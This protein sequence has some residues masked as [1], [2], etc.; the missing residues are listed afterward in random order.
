MFNYYGDTD[1]FREILTKSMEKTSFEWSTI[2]HRD[3]A[4]RLISAVP[5][6]CCN[7]VPVAHKQRQGGHTQPR[8]KHYAM[9]HNTVGETCGW[10]AVEAADPTARLIS[11]TLKTSQ[12]DKTTQ[13]N[14]QTQPRRR[15]GRLPKS[16]PDKPSPDVLYSDWTEAQR[17][18]A[19]NPWRT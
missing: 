11:T 13:D 1:F 14:L 9:A 12:Q 10:N 15:R 3:L 2:C 16:P 4:W 18:T 17:K 7:M 6:L 5:D 19:S 8:S